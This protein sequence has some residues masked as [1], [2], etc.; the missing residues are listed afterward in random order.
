M[1]PLVVLQKSIQKLSA[2]HNMAVNTMKRIVNEDLVMCSRRTG[3]DH[4]AVKMLWKG[5]KV[6]PETQEGK[7]RQVR[8]FSDKKLF[9]A[10]A[11]INYCNRKFLTD[12]PVSVVDGNIRISP[13][14]KTPAKVMVLGVVASNS[15]RDQSFSFPMAKRSLLTVNAPA[16]DT[17][18]LC[19]ESGE[20]LCVPAGQPC[21]CAHHQFDAEVP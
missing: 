5:Q 21:P 16:Q 7:L 8:I 9:I 4:H 6:V 12:L 1:P 14:S 19:H 17:L 11:L 18:A 10:D 20:Q 2:K 3:C 15:K 13:F